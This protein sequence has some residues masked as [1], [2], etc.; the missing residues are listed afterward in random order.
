MQTLTINSANLQATRPTWT[1]TSTMPNAAGEI[2]RWELLIDNWINQSTSINQSRHHTTRPIGVWWRQ[3]QVTAGICHLLENLFQVSVLAGDLK[4]VKIT[5]PDESYILTAGQNKDANDEIVFS[6]C[7]V[8]CTEQ[9]VL[10]GFKWV[11]KI[12]QSIFNNPV[13]Q[14]LN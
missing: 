12:S 10:V 14:L 7:A 8:K 9:E 11:D 2:Y 6:S 3:S 13:N 4:Y 1:A 5:E